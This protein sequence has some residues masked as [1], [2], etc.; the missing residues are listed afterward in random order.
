MS[1]SKP[2]ARGPGGRAAGSVA[3]AGVQVR[4]VPLGGSPLSRA[5]QRG[6]VPG[7]WR[8]TRPVGVDAWRTRAAEVR[9]DAARR[10]GAGAWAGTLSPAFGSAT[11]PAHARRAAAARQGIVVTTGQQPGL[12]GGPAYTLTKALSALALADALEA[13]LQ[14]PVAPVFWAA[15]DDADWREAAT[16]HVVGTD[17]LDTLALPG[18]P[19]EG[20][21][22]RDVPLGDLRAARAAL[23]AACG[24]MLA[25]GVLEQLEAAYADGATIGG[26]YVTWLRQLLEPLGISVLDAAHPS[27]REALDP[28][29]RAALRGATAIDGALRDRT[30][31]IVA[32]GFTPQV[33]LVDG[34]SLVFASPPEVSGARA[35][36]PVAD[37]AVAAT[38]LPAGT[39]G[40]NVLLRPVLERQLL[41]TV[42]YVAG[43][44]ELAYFA[45][46]TAVAE[47]LDVAVPL[48]VPRW[49][50]DWVEPQVARLMTRL[51]VRDDDLHD[52]HALEAR[53]ARGAMD[54][55]VADALARLRATL[56]AEVAALG[57][58]VAGAGPLVPAPVITGL[59]RDLG[60]RVDRVARRLLAAVKRREH[61]VTRQ[62]AVVRA[63][64]RPLGAAPE[65]A[66]SLVPVLARHG[67]VVLDL[68][69]A[70]AARHAAA[71]LHGPGIDA[72]SAP[73]A[74]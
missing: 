29:L 50:A 21:P 54:R 68:L 35:R 39:L 33:E 74:S 61:E 51:D 72:G 31:R 63:A 59:A 53:L 32:A 65:R 58:A 71:L 41:P 60:H 24:S 48:A 6:E 36:V 8:L 70:E 11:G 57:D 23:R 19:T 15:T 56:D 12:F 45:Q 46:V 1:E 67:L 64:R 20:Q 42:A 69:R 34:L 14:V 43:P 38:S 25:P 52:P 37:A 3:P 30:Q 73:G 22:L 9:A 62:V 49:A 27:V 44:G 26:A 5:I 55:P 4:T 7:A 16:V 47:A 40:A 13:H 66:L 2:D 17:G 10:G 28:G 18:P